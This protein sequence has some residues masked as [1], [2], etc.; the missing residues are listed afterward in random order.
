MTYSESIS[1]EST[2]TMMTLSSA[3]CTQRTS[4][5]TAPSQDSN[6]I[7]PHSRIKGQFPHLDFSPI[8]IA[9]TRE[10][11]LRRG[12]E[13]LRVRVEMAIIRLCRHGCP[14]DTLRLAVRAVGLTGGGVLDVDPVYAAGFGIAVVAHVHD[15]PGGIVGRIEHVADAKIA[16]CHGYGVGFGVKGVIVAVEV[17]E[18]KGRTRVQ[19]LALVTQERTQKGERRRRRGFSKAKWDD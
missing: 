2:L 3:T 19:L 14:D 15:E 12:V 7:D 11:L 1:A 18:L 17:E 9:P 5:N 16:S 6:A 8:R 10:N 4:K 13:E